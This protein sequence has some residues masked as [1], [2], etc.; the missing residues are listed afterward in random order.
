MNQVGKQ[1]HVEALS[2]WGE[3]P[4]YLIFDYEKRDPLTKDAFVS[5]WKEYGA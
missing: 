5:P 4:I 3:E 1:K 2:A